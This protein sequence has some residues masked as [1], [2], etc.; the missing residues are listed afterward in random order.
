M[1]VSEIV[2]LIA[3]RAERRLQRIPLG[4]RGVFAKPHMSGTEQTRKL[5]HAWKEGWERSGVEAR[6]VCDRRAFGKIAANDAI[7]LQR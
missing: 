3:R 4:T 5:R 2:A 1:L 6:S 7:T